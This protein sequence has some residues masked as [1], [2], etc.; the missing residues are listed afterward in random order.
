MRNERRKVF[1][2][3]VDFLTGGSAD[4]EVN[5][6]E[7]DQIVPFHDHPFRLYEGKRLDDMVE[8]IREHGVLNPVIVRKADAG[9]EMLAGHNRVNAAKIAGLTE[10]PAI[11]KKNISDEE[12]YV[13]VIETNL[14]Q[15]SFTDMLPSEKAAVLTE[16]YE[17]VVSQ[18]KRNDILKE[19]RMLEGEDDGPGGHDVHMSKSRDSLGTEYGMTGRNIARYIR[20]NKLIAPLKHM[21]DE[22]SLTLTAAVDLSYLST[23]EQELLAGCAEKIDGKTAAVLRA[24]TGSLTEKR[25]LEILN[26]PKEQKMEKPLSV[27]IPAEADRRYFSGMKPKEKADIIMKALEAWFAKEGR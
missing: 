19:I 3:A 7:I 26:P 15:R 5:T 25:I 13:Y 9:Y 6:I 27:K 10:V 11:I 22:G 17:K 21:L 24:E 23:Q 12:A 14:M 2:D 16:R 20:V 18:G 8:S 1:G 4:A